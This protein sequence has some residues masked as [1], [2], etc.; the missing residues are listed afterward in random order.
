MADVSAHR[1]CWPATA[2]ETHM[3]QW[4]E[5]RVGTDVGQSTTELSSDAVHQVVTA[6]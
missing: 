6:S 4:L 5:Q 3:N 2:I 1:E